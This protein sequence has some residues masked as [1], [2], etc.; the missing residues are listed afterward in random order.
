MR[1]YTYFNRDI[2]WLSSNERVLMEADKETVPLLER[3]KFISI[4]SSNLDEFYRVRMPVMLRHQQQKDNNEYDLANQIIDSQQSGLGTILFQ[5]ILPSLKA[6][7]IN[8]YYQDEI[9]QDLN[10]DITDYFFCHVAGLLQPIILCISL[11]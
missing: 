1:K 3:I 4:Y 11:N 5:S 10:D 6:I 9:P 2:S 7:G 8:F